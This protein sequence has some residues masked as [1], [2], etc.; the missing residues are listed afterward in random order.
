MRSLFSKWKNVQW[1]SGA[2][3]KIAFYFSRCKCTCVPPSAFVLPII[4]LTGILESSFHILHCFPFS[5]SLLLLYRGL[6]LLQLLLG[7]R[8][9]SHLLRVSFDQA[10]NPFSIRVTQLTGTLGEYLKWILLLGKNPIVRILKG[11]KDNF[12][13]QT[14]SFCSVGIYKWDSIVKNCVSTCQR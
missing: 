7:A 10:H 12:S 8:P 3:N 6:A 1:D 5:F 11:E 14:K 4:V 2:L 13:I 9:P